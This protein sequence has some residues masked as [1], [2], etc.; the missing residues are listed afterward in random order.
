MLKALRLLQ[1]Q[2]MV[3]QIG[4]DGLITE[5]KLTLKGISNM[6]GHVKLTSP[7]FALQRDAATP[8][9]LCSP[10]ALWDYLCMHGSCP[11]PIAGGRGLKQRIQELPSFQVGVDQRFFVF[12][13]A[14]K[15][16]MLS[17]ALAIER[18]GDA[19]EPLCIRHMQSDTY[20]SQVVKAIDGDIA[21]QV[22]CDLNRDDMFEDEGGLM[23]KDG[24]N[25]QQKRKRKP[26]MRQQRSTRKAV[27]DTVVIP[28]DNGIGDEENFE[29]DSAE[30]EP[31]PK[32]RRLMR[33]QPVRSQTEHAEP[34]PPLPAVSAHVVEDHVDN[35]LEAG[36]G[37]APDDDLELM[38]AEGDSG[39]VEEEQD[40]QVSSSSDSEEE[41]VAQDVRT[42]QNVGVTMHGEPWKKFLIG[43]G[44]HC[45][46]VIV[47]NE[48]NG[49]L[50]FGA[51]CN[52][53]AHARPCRLNRNCR[54]H[55]RAKRDLESLSINDQA[56]GRPLGLLVSWLM[57]SHSHVSKK[58]N[59][60][61]A[62]QRHKDAASNNESMVGRLRNRR[63]AR[64]WLLE[65]AAENDQLSYLLQLE[66]STHKGET[67]EPIGLC[68]GG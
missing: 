20:Y 65:L 7:R 41:Q 22:L 36:D 55:R 56:Q 34:Q 67:L 42:I 17:L 44:E 31:A 61:K 45:V 63:A 62:R 13:R 5:W 52:C 35:E 58:G 28:I 60:D 33:K 21:M 38:V 4:A 39:P 14:S 68:G 15:L 9:H 54:S 11:E 19:D 16:Y 40:A 1:T 46:G 3:E 48:M 18:R 10:Y 6:N 30:D 25:G 66:R 47:V 29:P 43:E 24:S 2:G 59:K 64:K 23:L 8:L 37:A 57:H 12:N 27:C 50:S 26:A 32:Q 49:G 53:G 51:H